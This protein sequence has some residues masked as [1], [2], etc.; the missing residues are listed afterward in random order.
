MTSRLIVLLTLL[1]VCATTAVAG[2]PTGEPACGLSASERA[3]LEAQPSSD[4]LSLRAGDSEVVPPVSA[5][6]RAELA[7]AAASA[8]DLDELRAGEEGPSEIEI[9]GAIV[10][11]I[12][13][14]LLI[15]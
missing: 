14:A 11:V 4:L 8:Q 6:E 13:L 1:L 2:D 12:V 10:G 9:V 7:Q 15:F 5:A 3:A